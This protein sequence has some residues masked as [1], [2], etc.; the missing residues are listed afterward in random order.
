MRLQIFKENRG[1]S[2]IYRWINLVNGKSY[3]G[4]S[5]DLS[6]R[7]KNHL[8]SINSNILLQRAILKYGISSFSIQIL[9]YCDKKQ[10]I[11]KEQF[12]LNLFKSEY[13]LKPTAGSLL[14]YK[15][16]P[17]SIEKM[18]QSRLGEKN[19]FFGKIHSEETRMKISEA[20]KNN[21]NFL[22]KVHSQSSKDK[23]SKALGIT[24]YVYNLQYELLYIFTSTR[25]A[26]QH[27]SS[28][29]RT[30]LK[31]AKSGN[32]FQK[33]YILSLEVLSPPSHD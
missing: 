33:K 17:E 25:A 10:L 20:M 28:C 24:I 13:N 7:L 18:S 6:K 3:I 26:A 1:K 30:I 4:S 2:G 22:G 11:S 12:Y 31:Y 27:F 29:K 23:I 14:G 5:V 19:H 9:E 8:Y 32:I 15:H 21:K 16:T